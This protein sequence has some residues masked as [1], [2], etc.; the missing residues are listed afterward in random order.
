MAFINELTARW[1]GAGM[2]ARIIAVNVALFLVIRLA[3]VVALVARG[4]A[5]DVLRW[6]M[7]PPGLGQ[8]V[9]EP[10]TLLTYMFCHY[11]LL[12]LLCNMVWLYWFGTL[13]MMMCTPK[14]LFALYIYGG[15]A[16]AMLYTALCG[17]APWLGGGG[18]IGASASILAIVVAVAVIS[19]DFEVN[20]LLVGPVK[21]KWIAVATVVLLALGLSGDNLGGHAAHLGGILVGLA[22]GSAFRR[23]TDI[24]RPFNRLLDR[25]FSFRFTAARQPRP[26]ARRRQPASDAEEMADIDPI[27]AKIKL[28]GYASLTAEERRRLFEASSRLKRD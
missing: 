26:S 10:W 17:L 20:L 21:L 19:P 6:V 15:L 9:T 16:G 3:A 1:R 23:G 11:E 22:Y 7:V 5:D 4:G 2:T 27:L 8:L 24:T 14:Q 28:S 13:M 25:L 18:L 12:H